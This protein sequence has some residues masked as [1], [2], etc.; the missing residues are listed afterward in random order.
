MDRQ[1]VFERRMRLASITPL[2]QRHHRLLSCFRVVLLRSFFQRIVEADSVRLVARSAVAAL[3]IAQVVHGHA[4]ANHHRA[5]VAQGREGFAQR[6]MLRWVVRVEERD[7]HHGDIQRVL[8]WVERYEERGENA[9][10]QASADAF[11]FDASTLQG[12]EDL[13]CEFR[14]AGVGILDCVVVW[15]EAVVVVDQTLGCCSVDF[16]GVAVALP[17]R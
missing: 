8:L 9:V 15:R 4:G 1:Q 3:E 13:V 17:V 14:G 5:F 11:G 10:I 12:A 6:E 16:D 2:Q 7:L